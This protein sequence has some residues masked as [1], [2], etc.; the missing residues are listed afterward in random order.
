DALVEVGLATGPVRDD[1]VSAASAMAS[2]IAA[3]PR[4]AAAHI[5]KLVRGAAG[6]DEEAARFGAE[7]ALFCDLMLRDDSRALVSEGAAGRRS[8][9]DLP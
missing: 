1:A 5:K 8:I 3:R 7:R 6:N 9:T 2:R 4:P